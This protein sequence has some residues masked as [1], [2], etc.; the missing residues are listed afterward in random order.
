[1]GTHKLRA[2]QCA[3]AKPWDLDVDVVVVTEVKSH[4]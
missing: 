2:D 1:M 3:T 4:E